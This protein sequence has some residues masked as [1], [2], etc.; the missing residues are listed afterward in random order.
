MYRVID[1]VHKHTPLAFVALTARFSDPRPIVTPGERFRTLYAGETVACAI[2]E[3]VVRDSMVQTERV[4][5]PARALCARTMVEIA[6]NEPLRLL[7]ITGNH[8]LRINAGTEVTKGADHAPGRQLSG[9]LFADCPEC[10]GIVYDSR[11]TGHR[12]LML[13]QRAADKL[14]PQSRVAPLTDHPLIQR[15][16]TDNGLHR[17]VLLNN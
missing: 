3:A 8:Y 10:D 1:N 13:Y 11:Y 2:W 9:Q 5:I 14:N 7:D 6:W 15:Y 4:Y 17:D 12:C 16:L